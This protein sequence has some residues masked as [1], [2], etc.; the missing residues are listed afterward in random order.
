MVRF[1]GSSEFENKSFA[2]GSR[3]AGIVIHDKTRMKSKQ[4]VTRKRCRTKHS[5]VMDSSSARGTL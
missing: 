1:P 5:E 2:T 3:K 4:I